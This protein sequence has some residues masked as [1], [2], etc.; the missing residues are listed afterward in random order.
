[1]VSEL[2]MQ[3]TPSPRSRLWLSVDSLSII[4]PA[5]ALS[6]VQSRLIALICAKLA[7]IVAFPS[8]EVQANT[9]LCAL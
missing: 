3:A 5:T 9:L 4:L 2:G 7:V 6:Q 1:M 8:F